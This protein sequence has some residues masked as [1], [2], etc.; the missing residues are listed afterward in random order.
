MVG[1]GAAGGSAGGG[2]RP[3]IY[4]ANPYGFAPS[5]RNHLLPPLR[6]AIEALGAEVFEPF[7]EAS[8]LAS[9]MKPG[10]AY[11]VGQ[12]DLAGVRGADALFA[13]VNGTPPDEG[14]MIELGYAMALAKPVF[15]FRD[16]W[17]KCTESEE[18]PLNLMV[19]SGLPESGWQEFLYQNV[20]EV[21]SAEKALAKWIAGRA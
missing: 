15:L 4:L 7:D 1:N 2:G 10:W 5:W 12:F 16:D 11:R 17:R 6:A 14:V 9:P 19:F 18:Y 3:L 8:K 13:V 20:A 21:R